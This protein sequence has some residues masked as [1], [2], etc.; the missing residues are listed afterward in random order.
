MSLDI[1][2]QN[3]FSTLYGSDP[4]EEV[5]VSQSTIDFIREHILPKQPLQPLQP[6]QPPQTTS[7]LAS[8]WNA[9]SEQYSGNMKL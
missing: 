9:D 7:S 3:L 6:L 8:R 4:C 5:K 2:K 1:Q